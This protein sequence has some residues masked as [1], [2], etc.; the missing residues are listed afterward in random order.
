METI[1]LILSGVILAAGVLYWFW[2]HI[3]LTQKKVQLLENAVFELRG[4]MTRGDPGSEGG[5]SQAPST[6]PAPVYQ[7]L[8]D[9]EEE[10]SDASAPQPSKTADI[11]STPL[12]AL[13][14][15]VTADLQPG[16][17]LEVP[18]PGTPENVPVTTDDQFR[19]LFLQRSPVPTPPAAAAAAAVTA[20]SEKTVTTGPAPA[21]APAAVSNEALEAMPVKDLRRLAEQRGLTGVSEMRKKEILSALRQQIPATAVAE[22]VPVASEPQPST[23]VV[24]E[25]TLDL[26]EGIEE[27]TVLE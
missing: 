27:A 23:T 12:S 15:D 7:D 13:S 11:G 1:F 20:S 10:W 5:S 16:G 6:P 25:R 19:E 4:L 8:A 3:Q 24:V 14:G 9:D 22:S 26:T 17:R 2:S 18:S 21:P